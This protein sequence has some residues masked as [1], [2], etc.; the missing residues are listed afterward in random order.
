MVIWLLGISGSGKSTLGNKIKEYFDKQGRQSFILDGD[1][2]RNFYDNDLG[3]SIEERRQNIKRILL[4]AY[5][6][7]KNKIVTIVCN[8]SPFEDLREFARNKFNDYVQIYL[9]KEIQFAQQDDVKNVYKD[10]LS[11]TPI[12]G[13]DLVFDEPTLN[14][15]VLS[16]DV[17][18]VDTSFS[19]IVSYLTEKNKSEN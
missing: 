11:K 5:V 13:I 1:I 19:K 18:C 16:V 8:I 9:K 2:V 15:L 10:N 17:E 12:V 3:Y 4:A 14:E 7:E 6:L